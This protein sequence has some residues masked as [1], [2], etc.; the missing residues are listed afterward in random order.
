MN[1]SCRTNLPR[2]LVKPFI[3]V[4]LMMTLVL[5]AEGQR[6]QPGFSREE[7]REMLYITARTC[8][9]D[10]NYL[11]SIPA[12]AL[13][14]LQYR[15]AETGLDNIWELWTGREA[16]VISIRGTT[17]KAESWSENFYAAMVQAKGT[18]QLAGNRLFP[19][20]LATDERAA[21][22]VGW[23]LGLAYMSE[24]IT[25]HIDSLYRGGVK[26]FFLTGH[27]QGGALTYLL[28]AYLYER[29]RAGSLPGDIR[30]KTYCSAAPKPGNLYFAYHYEKLTRN[31]LAFNIVNSADWVPETPVSI[32]TLQD[33]N[34]VNPFVHAK[35]VIRKMKFPKNMAMK[36]VYKK[37]SKPTLKAQ[38][39]YEKYLGKMTSKIVGKHLPGFQ[40][41]EYYPSNHYVRTGST[42]VLTPDEAYYR[43]YP[44]DPAKIFSHHF[45]KPYLY[46]LDRL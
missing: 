39:N 29:Q 1:F 23:L 12:P 30:F 31:G 17:E 7:F 46:L 3:L 18:L 19:Y 11:K 25:G 34:T 16:A 45:H 13:F 9:L 28:T 32:Q 27:S 38:R 8:A 36:H 41:P 21:V 14:S 33:F 37:L 22:H 42:V 2:M 24:D 4:L 5:A 6:I 40:A 10:T 26:D 35:G 15:S 43:E 20:T 44:N